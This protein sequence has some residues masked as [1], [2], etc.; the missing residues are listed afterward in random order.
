MKTNISHIHYFDSVA[1]F[2]QHLSS[3]EPRGR[4]AN[5]PGSQATYDPVWYGSESYEQADEWLAHGDHKA[6]ER[7]GKALTKMQV[8]VSS[9]TTST[10]TRADYV[11]FAPCV[12]N[13]VAGVPQS[14]YNRKRVRKP[15]PVITICYNTGATAGYSAD[16]IAECGATLLEA[17]RA[18]EAGGIRVNLYTAQVSSSNGH[19]AGPL[20]RIKDADQPLDLLKCAYPL[21][22]PSMLR[23]H[24]FAFLERTAGIPQSFAGSYGS[25]IKDGDILKQVKLKG[26]KFDAVLTFYD[27]K[28]SAVGDVVNQIRQQTK[29]ALIK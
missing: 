15:Q 29:D 9:Y 2:R 19:Y 8:Q 16:E 22:S 26:R 27:V 23:R 25:S 3:N 28:G 13:F 11:G 24:K 14:M 12:A 21:T 18:I 7:I 4:F 6:A 17:V 5:S 20:I 10:R 1:E